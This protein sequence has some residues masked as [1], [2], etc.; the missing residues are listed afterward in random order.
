MRTHPSNEI[1]TRA[2]RLQSDLLCYKIY[3]KSASPTLLDLT[4]ESGH[5]S[6]VQHAAE[7]QVVPETPA[8]PKLT[9][10]P[11][12]NCAAHTPAGVVHTS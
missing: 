11:L 9:V 12:A 10:A 4:L 2:R 7:R 5:D 8:Q 6:E 3:R 1:F